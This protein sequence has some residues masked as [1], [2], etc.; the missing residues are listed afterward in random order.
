MDCA[1]TGKLIAQ[2]RKE[3]EFTQQNLADAIGVTNKTVSKWEC[4]LGFP[5]S[6]VW[7]D[8]SQILG[9]DMMQVME[10]EIT[11]NEPDIGNIN[12]IKFYVCPVCS[13]VL[14]S[15][16]SSTIYCCGKKLEAVKSTWE[17]EESEYSVELM[18]M[19]YYVSL[20]HP[21]EKNDYILFF[22]YVKNDRVYF[23]RMYPEQSSEV[24]FPMMKGG[25]LYVYST[26]KGLSKA[27]KI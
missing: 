18:D 27:I 6:S 25:K 9:V 22:A 12:R 26:S 24:R 3:K 19:D 5:D 8:L 16:G 17:V 10:G 23:Y 13:N 15:T 2:L 1:K 20:K 7:S 4:G 21:M 14:I 11:A